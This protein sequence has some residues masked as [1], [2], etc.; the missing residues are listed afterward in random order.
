M[1]GKPDGC[2]SGDGW[3]ERI[4]CNKFMLTVKIMREDMKDCSTEMLATG[5]ILALDDDFT[6]PLYCEW[7][8]ET[9][10]QFVAHHEE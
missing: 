7:P 8:K 2:T 9:L 5:R 10:A 3:S 1:L 6:D 4:F